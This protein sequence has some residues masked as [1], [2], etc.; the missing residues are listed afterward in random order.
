ME[1]A[2]ASY[3]LSDLEESVLRGFGYGLKRTDI[4]SQ[5]E[6]PPEQVDRLV[7]QT[8]SKLFHLDRIVRSEA[9]CSS[10]ARSVCIPSSR[11]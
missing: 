11:G 7:A 4:A 5:L 2:V 1:K 6:I 8:Y 3:M 9:T 10:V